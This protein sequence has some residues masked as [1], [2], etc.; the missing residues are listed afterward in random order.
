M[1]KVEQ[2]RQDRSFERYGLQ[3]FVAPQIYISY[4]A[5]THPTH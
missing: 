5:Q 2:Q 1:K 4:N 3:E